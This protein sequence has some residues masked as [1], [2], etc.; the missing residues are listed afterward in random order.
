MSTNDTTDVI[1]QNF[2]E[3]EQSEIALAEAYQMYE[4]GNAGDTG[5]LHYDLIAKMAGMVKAGA[6]GLRGEAV[7]EHFGEVERREIDFSSLYRN[8]FNH[9]TSGHLA[10]NVIA[11]LWDLLTAL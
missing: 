9:G 4:H 3:R 6:T 10:R 5:D 11:K 2:D 8:K 7:A 1:K